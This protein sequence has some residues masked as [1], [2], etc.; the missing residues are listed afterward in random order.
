MSI[1]NPVIKVGNKV[2]GPGWPSG[3]YLTITAVGEAG[4]L[5][6]PSSAPKLEIRYVINVPGT[7]WQQYVEPPTDVAFINLYPND[8]R[9][10][11]RHSKRSEAS[12]V[13]AWDREAIA[14]RNSNGEWRIE[15]V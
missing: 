4:F 2:C 7:R 11:R 10:M 12:F 3:E 1:S 8:N 5:A 15:N 14:I 9:E 6:H 13:A